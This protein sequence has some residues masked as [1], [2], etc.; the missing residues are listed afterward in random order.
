[1]CV[2]ARVCVCLCVCV[3]IYI[4]A[5]QGGNPVVRRGKGGEGCGGSWGWEEGTGLAGVGRRELV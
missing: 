2:R 5:L 4:I 1:V 3:Y